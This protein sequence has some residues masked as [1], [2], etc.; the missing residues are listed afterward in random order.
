MTDE[1]R[2]SNYPEKSGVESQES[3]V[4]NKK[5]WVDGYESRIPTSNVW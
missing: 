4:E 2:A 1:E 3:R 5:S